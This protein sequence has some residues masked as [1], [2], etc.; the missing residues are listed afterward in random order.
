MGSPSFFPK[1]KGPYEVETSFFIGRPHWCSEDHIRLFGFLCS[2]E[3]VGLLQNCGSC[4]GWTHSG[5]RR[6]GRSGSSQ[7]HL[8]QTL[9]WALRMDFASQDPGLLL[10]AIWSSLLWTLLRA[11]LHFLHPVLCR[12][13]TQEMPNVR[14]FYGWFTA[15]LTLFEGRR[16]KRRI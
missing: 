2:A 15:V 9:E 8:C 16:I 3:A 13:G 5:V 1:S 4:V 10:S 11:S 6:F 14:E 12:P 7:L